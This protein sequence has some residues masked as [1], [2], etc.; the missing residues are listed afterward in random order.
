MNLLP[1]F[2]SKSKLLKYFL[3]SAFL[4]FITAG[5]VS[6]A[7]GG[8]PNPQPCKNPLPT[9]PEELVDNYITDENG[10]AAI[11]FEGS[12]TL[13]ITGLPGEEKEL[14]ARTF[15]FRV[16][17]SK[18]Q[19][20]FANSNS[21][22][23]EGQ[24]QN[25]EHR[26][27]DILSLNS[28]DFNTFHGAGQKTSP[29]ILVDELKAN[30]V[31]YVYNK[32]ELAESENRYTNIEGLGDPK[33]IYDLV[34]EFGLPSPPPSAATEEER[35]VW[36]TT[37]G[38][39]WG[40]IPTAY[41]EFYEGEI[42]FHYVLGIGGLTR[43]QTK[44][45]CPLRVEP[46]IKLVLPEFFR[47]TAISD[48]LNRQI[49]AGQA[50]SFQE[51]EILASGKN[52]IQKTFAFCWELIKN[53][54]GSNFRKIVS[55]N[56]PQL[57]TDAFAQENQSCIKPLQKGKQGEAPYCPLPFSEANQP[58]VSCQNRDDPNKLESDN[59]NVVCSFTRT[60]SG[61]RLT[62]DPANTIANDPENGVFDSCSQNADGT[63]TCSVSLRI[64]PNIRVP[65]LAAIWNNTIYSDESENL[66][67]Q[68]TGRPGI[69]G[70][71]TP[72]SVALS[73]GQDKNLDELLR[74]RNV[75]S[76]PANPEFGSLDCIGLIGIWNS[77]GCDIAMSQDQFL[78]CLG[79]SRNK[80]GETLNSA[81]DDPKERLIGSTDCNKEFVRDF[82]LKPKVLQEGSVFEICKDSP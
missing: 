10:D 54:V 14:P 42:A 17:F 46:P 35:T 71:F 36:L 55:F 79:Y 58:G 50:Q 64:F 12:D 4:V 57:I 20:L 68:E 40:K 61:I 24:F 74:I 29:K 6:A 66:S 21:N 23:L 49:V 82:S 33:T 60:I 67:N 2:H 9:S 70:F 53:S 11:K 38:N 48:Q 32:P 80:P 22:Y 43:L 56:F 28:Q 8:P 34:N 77:L 18:L 78:G 63:F 73:F 81:S 31:E 26:F 16:D 27:E 1:G 45:V 7:P 52:I 25:N 62:I 15:T 59:P 44:N 30:Y 47:T 69:Y 41:S 37:W 5:S 72:K 65:W 51:H 13:T 19:S 39:Y 75:C 3:I 76:D